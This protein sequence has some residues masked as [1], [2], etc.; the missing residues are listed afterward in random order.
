MGTFLPSAAVFVGM[1]KIVFCLLTIVVG[2][3]FSDSFRIYCAHRKR[4]CV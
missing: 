4:R 1:D 2:E 3:H